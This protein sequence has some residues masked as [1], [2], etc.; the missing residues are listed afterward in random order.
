MRRER[1]GL[2]ILC[3][4]IG[5]V[6]WALNFSFQ[7]PAFLSDEIGYLS[8]AAVLA[9]WT[10]NLHTG[11]HGG[12]SLFLAPSFLVF[13]EPSQ[14][15]RSAVFTNAC[16]WFI[17]FAS[18]WPIL[19]KLS[20]E[21]SSRRRLGAMALCALYPTW[22]VSCGYTIATSALALLFTLSA[23]GL[24]RPGWGGLLLHSIC[25][26]LLFWCHPTG[27]A[28]AA[29]SVLSQLLL[30]RRNSV[31]RFLT[32]VAVIGLV[33]GAYRWGLSPWFTQA[34]TA[35]NDGA[36]LVSSTGGGRYSTGGFGA[37]L[38]SLKFYKHLLVMMMGQVSYFLVCTFGIGAYGFLAII[39]Q[40]RKADQKLVNGYLLL[41]LLGLM[42]MGALYLSKLSCEYRT[43]GIHTW[44]YGRYQ[45]IVWLPL[46]ALGLLNPW[47]RKWMV[48]GTLQTLFTGG[49][50]YVIL[51]PENTDWS[52]IF[53]NIQGF[54]PVAVYP[55]LTPWVWFAIGAAGIALVGAL[56]RK[57][58]PLLALPLIAVTVSLQ[59]TRHHQIL[60]DYSRPNDMRTVVK[61]FYPPGT[62]AVLD[63]DISAEHRPGEQQE[64]PN[65]YSFYLYDYP[66][67][68]V[69]FED[70]LEAPQGPY[71]TYDQEKAS[72]SKVRTV[73]L[74]HK[75]GLLMLVPSTLSTGISPQSK[76][77][78]I[79]VDPEQTGK[80]ALGCFT[81][82]APE[83][84]VFSAT[85]VLT[86]RGLTTSHGSGHLFYGPYLPLR[87]GRY[88]LTLRGEFS[89]PA[90]AL[91]EVTS[92]AGES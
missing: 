52:L 12:Y 66:Q 42:V 29:A 7:G 59:L 75:T 48:A 33:I 92:E 4:L 19:S 68:K 53:L 21:A 20:P 34:M 72:S 45:E 74:E 6:Y 35:G 89:E 69:P 23:L 64:R 26:G 50:L 40:L 1:G 36:V 78:G 84:I 37:A 61:L 5:L 91:L 47:P 62:S 24:L 8:K 86:E 81:L 57:V 22:I 82:T 11:W 13:Q 15:F 3:L 2:V 88:K 55:A 49:L 90:E 83:L 14:I 9:G 54:W 16:L 38:G 41:S 65:F 44:F 71:F 77:R 60:S 17:T 18:L 70:W 58:S 85:G 67:H 31:I 56:P 30:L 76:F 73:A 46:I 80:L 39:Q 79:S 25:V 28:V 10:I 32:S 87:A 27:L 43:E 63:P 51:T